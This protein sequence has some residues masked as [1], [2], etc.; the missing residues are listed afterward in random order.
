MTLNT[1][2]LPTVDWLDL[3]RAS[4]SDGVRRPKAWAITQGCALAVDR[5]YQGD[6][7]VAS[8]NALDAA[9]GPLLDRRG[10]A[11]GEARGGLGDDEYRRIIA[12][13]QQT[14][15]VDG[16]VDAEWALWLALTGV[17][18]EDAAIRRYGPSGGLWL[19]ARVVV[20]P[21]EAWRIRA[22]SL[23][24]DALGRRPLSAVLYTD[25]TMR[26]TSLPGWSVGVWAITLV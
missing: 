16:T 21:T 9:V 8:S 17:R 19:T 5:A 2:T 4:S 11:V 23:L 10:A 15:D 13:R 18:P 3:L 14:A 7:D 24:V 20:A 1:Q 22:R 25:Q 26:W 12:A 6:A